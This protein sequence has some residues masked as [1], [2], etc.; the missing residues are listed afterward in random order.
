MTVI[1]M[2]TTPAFPIP[3][4][5][6]VL[7]FFRGASNNTTLNRESRAYQFRHSTVIFL[8]SVATNVR[9]FWIAIG[10]C[11]QATAVDGTVF[12]A[13]LPFLACQVDNLINTPDGR[14][15][16]V[17]GER[18]AVVAIDSRE[19]GWHATISL[20][21]GVVIPG[22]KISIITKAVA[23]QVAMAFIVS[24]VGLVSTQHAGA[25]SDG[26]K[27]R[28]GMMADFNPFRFRTRLLIICICLFEGGRKKE[29]DRSQA[30]PHLVY[31]FFFLYYY[32]VWPRMIIRLNKMSFIFVVAS[33]QRSEEAASKMFVSAG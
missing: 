18:I 8:F 15:T 26:M 23:M 4:K 16:R 33:S 32:L 24:K 27:A 3:L 6:C 5:S 29:K 21:V 19:R 1:I 28:F 11:A 12:D 30:K 2:I 14:M 25:D 31:F 9:I 13:R 22:T 7:E 17:L 10:K 20:T